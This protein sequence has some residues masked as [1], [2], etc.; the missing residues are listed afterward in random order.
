MI[1]QTEVEIKGHIKNID[2]FRNLNYDIEYRKPVMVKVTDLM[3]GSTAIIT[4]ICDICDNERNMQFREYHDYTNGLITKYYCSKCSYLKR[5]ETC[6]ERYGV[7]NPMKSEEVKNTLKESLMNKYGID[8]YS[9]TDEYKEKF[10][11]TCLKKFGTENP[12]SSEDIKEKI[13]ETNNKKHGVDYPQQN[14]DIKKKTAETYNKKWG[15]NRY[16]QTEEWKE[17]IKITSNEKWGVDN[18]SQTEECK[19]KVRIT[20]NEKWGFNSYTQ[21]DE[22]KDRLKK[23]RES[24]TK[25]K[26]ENLI[27]NDFEVVE[28]SE[29][30]FKILHKSCNREFSIN[31]DLLYQRHNLNVCICTKCFEVS[32]G[33]SNM[34][35]EMQ[36]FLDSIGID[37]IIK[38]RSIL[39]GKELDIYIPSHN[40]AIEMNGL[41]WHSEIYLDKNY[42]INKTNLCKENGINLI[43]IWEDD[44]KFKR[45]II[46]S[47][48][49]NRLNLIEIKIPARKCEIIS[50]DSSVASKFL[51]ENHIQGSS[52]SQIRLGLT[53]DNELVSVMTFG[54]RYTNGKKE[55]E[56][57]RF[58]NKKNTNIIGGASKLFNN[59]IKGYKGLLISYSDISMF[60]GNLYDKLGFENVSR[61]QPNYYWIV[62]NI[63]RHRFNFNK[64]KLVKMGYDSSKTEVEIMHDLGHFRVFSCGQEKW[65]YEN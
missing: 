44:W 29:S 10:K 52:N 3:P 21:T 16:S 7:D 46:K 49:L 63:K 28:Y 18:Y 9:K 42:H 22:F 53:Y 26:Y 59:F 55:Y 13:K 24:L 2:H 48:I 5:K 43:H 33:Y 20:S 62:D 27:G 58:C 11:E 50:I 37:Y 36:S 35:L 51:D 38:N 4:S 64:K 8:H 65:I 40:I 25:L 57:I 34:E 12:F 30:N 45:D 56:L 19:E 14:E 61:S 32:M 1:K 6:L 39:N 41:Y 23:G 60:T 54:Y 17:K 31:R 15:V 47:I